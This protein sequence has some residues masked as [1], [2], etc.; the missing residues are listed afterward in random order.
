[1]GG[2][3]K[4]GHDNLRGVANTDAADLSPHA[5]HRASVTAWVAVSGTAMT[6]S[7]REI[8]SNAIAIHALTQPPATKHHS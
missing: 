2:R 8:I 5:P 1:V 3:V 6:I 7:A 4:R